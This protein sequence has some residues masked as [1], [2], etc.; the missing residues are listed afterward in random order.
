MERHWRLGDTM[1]EGTNIDTTEK[2]SLLLSNHLYSFEPGAIES[3]AL[4]KR[5]RFM[6]HLIFT[7]CLEPNF[8]RH[9]RSLLS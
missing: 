3:N 5:C 6:K 9:G 1:I 8:N 7:T 4:S 2:Y